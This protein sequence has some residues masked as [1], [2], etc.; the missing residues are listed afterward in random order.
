MMNQEKNSDEL[1]ICKCPVCGSDTCKM[2][3]AGEGEFESRVCEECGFMT[4]NKFIPGSPE[5]EMYEKTTAKIIIALRFED[6][7]LNQFWYP[8]T[9]FINSKGAVFPVGTVENWNYGYAPVVPVAI[10][11][12][13]QYPIPGR[14]GDY[15]EQRLAVE[16]T[17]LCKNFKEAALMLL[18]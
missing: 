15:Y 14:T 1:M 13:L 4:T 16:K 8:S 2:D 7:G 12:R 17:V 3:I 11:E 18:D 10:H 9:L 6:K 5:V